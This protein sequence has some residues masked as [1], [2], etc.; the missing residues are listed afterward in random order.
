MP[1]IITQCFFSNAATLDLAST[2]LCFADFLGALAQLGA[3][4]AFTG[5]VCAGVEVVCGAVFAAPLT[6]DPQL[7][8]KAASGERAAPHVAQRFDLGVPHLPQN[9]AS[10]DN[11][12]PQDEHSSSE[13]N[14]APQFPQNLLSGGLS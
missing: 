5:V 13:G 8:Q 11:G 2:K 6:G 10:G 12:A 14:C 4:C 3:D 9:A 7:K 1:F